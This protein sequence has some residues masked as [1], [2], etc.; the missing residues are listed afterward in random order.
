M[1]YTTAHLAQRVPR[2]RHKDPRIARAPLLRIM[3][4]TRA[5]LAHDPAG[6]L[7]SVTDTS[8]NVTTV[9]RDAS[10]TA[11]LRGPSVG[12]HEV[13][14]ATASPCRRYVPSPNGRAQS[15]T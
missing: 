11:Y 15:L 12:K 7:L 5:L 1:W 6:R 2:A 3:S 13:H 8:G 9:H 14:G 10:G 4:D